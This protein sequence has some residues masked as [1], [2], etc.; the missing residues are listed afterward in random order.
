MKEEKRT[1]MVPQEYPVFIAYD[2][3]EFSSKEDCETHEKIKKGLAKVCPDCKGKKFR[4]YTVRDFDPM[5]RP[6]EGYRSIERE[7][8]GECP[9]CKGKGYLK[10]KVTWE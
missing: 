2:G 5:W 6:V 8:Y 10:K 1:K 9:T 3:T 4:N 7:E